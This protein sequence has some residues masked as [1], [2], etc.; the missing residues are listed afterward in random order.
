MLAGLQLDKRPT[1]WGLCIERIFFHFIDARRRNPERLDDFSRWLGTFGEEHAE[2]RSR[3]AAVDY[4]FVSLIALRLELTEL[5]QNHFRL[6][7]V[8]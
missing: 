2:L 8:A 1:D 6:K 4:Y 7:V 3:L 5:I